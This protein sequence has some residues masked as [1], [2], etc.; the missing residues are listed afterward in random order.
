MGRVGRDVERAREPVAS[1]WE[2]AELVIDDGSLQ[3]WDEDVVSADPLAFADVRP[4]RERLAQARERTGLGE[5]ALTG[6]ATVAG[7]PIA[8]V[9]SE[10]GFLG[11]SIGTATGER[12]ARAFER[13]IE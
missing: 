11:G 9:A 6:R 10:F 8:L 7:R 2:R 1:A 12:V 5:S 13:A 3:P 4:Y